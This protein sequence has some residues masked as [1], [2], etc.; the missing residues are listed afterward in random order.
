MEH[1][2]VN[3]I[4]PGFAPDPSLVQVDGTY[5][6]VNSSFHMFPGLPIYASKDL[7]SWTQIGNAINRRSQLSLQQSFTKLYGPEDTDERMAAEGGLF[8]PT[9]R[10]HKGTFYIVCTNVMN[11]PDLPPAESDLHNFILSTRDIWANEWSDPVFYD[12]QSIDPSL[13]WDDDGKVY[14]IGAAGFGPET[15]I[16]QF[17]ID[18]ETGKKLSEERLLWEG[19]TKV[20]PEGPHM[21][22]KD[23]W[24]YLLIAEGGCFADHHTNMARSMNIWGP[25]E[26]NPANP[27][28][29]KTDPNDYI[30]YTGHGDLFQDASGQWYFVCLGVR[31]TKE[32]RFI[33]GRES[34]L[35]TARWP[36]GEYP[37]ID[38]LK[39]DVPIH[40]G[41]QE[42]P[43][44]PFKDNH[45]SFTPRL[46]LLHIRDPIEDHYEYHGRKIILTANKTKLD[47][48]GEPVTFVGKRQRLLEGKA[49]VVL[50]PPLN[51]QC[52][53]LE[54]GI[55]YYKD[56][57]RF[58]R[59]FLNVKS[60]EVVW[61]IV[62][63]ARYIGRRM[64]RS[65]DAFPTGGSH[66]KLRF[67][68]TYT[69]SA[70]VF[71]Y[72][73]DV[74]GNVGEPEVMGM[75]DTL[76]M[77]GHDFVGPVVGIFATGETETKVHFRNFDVDA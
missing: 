75:I 69:E 64:V 25:Y 33:L 76:E 40:G 20:Y 5:F 65:L 56:E 18:L 73:A 9:I 54:A 27:V 12:F 29:A 70:I 37:S 16:R 42:R 35:T 57:L 32:G 52:G 48:A 77:T 3:P 36:A 24:Y 58:C 67:E 2:R 23:G 44:W 14:V 60:R 68:I 19:I 13:F 6:L 28:L 71:S 41:V 4:I 10:Y 51:G 39:L 47:Q 59:I 46:D 53:A 38:V 30:Q 49:S 66:A 1:L 45:T 15:K 34:V 7:V 72:S 26:A 55:A 62:N 50:D 8:A 43:E 11:H 22:K 63:K 17:Q 31:K 21:Y 61:E 74:D